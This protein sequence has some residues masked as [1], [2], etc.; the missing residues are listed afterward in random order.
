VV[1][2]GGTEHTVHELVQV[3][4]RR[5]CA[6]VTWPDRELKMFTRVHLGPCESRKVSLSI[7]V[8][9]LWIVDANADYVVEPGPCEL[10]VGSSAAPE[11]LIAARFEL[12]AAD[13]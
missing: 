1:R 3:Y 9:D 4:V 11:S 6:S 7:P 5:L 13:L 10:L 2:N 12:V 8:A